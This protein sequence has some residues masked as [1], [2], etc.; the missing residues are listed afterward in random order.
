MKPKFWS[1]LAIMLMFAVV[2]YACAEGK[3]GPTYTVSSISGTVT[4]YGSAL[5]GVTITLSGASSATT[6]TDASGNYIFKGLA[7]G[8]YTVT[9]SMKGYI[10]NPVS[11]PVTIFGV[12]STGDNFAVQY[13]I[14]SGTVTGPSVSGILV[15]LSGVSSTTT[16]TTDASGKYTFKV[17]AN[18]TYT[19]TPSMTG[20]TFSP[21]NIAVTISGADS[22][23]DNFATQLGGAVQSNP[24]KLAM[25]VSTLA[26]LAGTDGSADGTGT[27]AL[28]HSPQGITSDGTNLYV[29][30]AGND[31]IRQI[32][33]STGAVTTL[34]GKAGS[35]GSADGTGT[36]ALF[37]SPQG[38]TSD[39]TNLYIAD[40]GNNTIR[41]ISKNKICYPG[42]S[43]SFCSYT[44]NTVTTLAGKA[45]S[46]GSADGTGTAA[47]FNSPQG[48]TTDG[49]N[50]YVADTGNDTIRQ[51]VI[52]TGAVTTLVGTAGTS[53]SID[54]TGT[55]A[56]FNS[57]QGI[58]MDVTNLYVADA[59]N[60]TIRQI[61]IA[62]GAVTTLAGT[63]GATGSADGTGTAARF[64]SPQGITMD[65]TDLY[66]A[67]TGNDTIR[68]IVIA[69]GAVTT[70]VGTAG[71]TGSTDGTG[72]AARFYYPEGMT[73][74]GTN[75]YVADTGNDTIRKIQ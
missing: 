43:A 22:T 69:T 19:V 75:L 52:S 66:V 48:I 38:I 30:D 54:G 29:A 12:T 51:I 7:N 17:L 2:L 13:Y 59:G 34:A 24:L 36:A 57:P 73:T 44:L 56:R 31:T 25:A 65:V 10:F 8:E 1:W 72:T 60:D 39:G 16:T 18:G 33:I 6:T 35:S 63:A 9:P 45:G 62:T 28:F 49:I 40:T 64:N 70:L 21:L 5:Q 50:L 53:G 37:H 20:Y 11:R 61:V 3:T 58:T 4:L 27:A 26:G 42:V 47:L 74:D 67:D 55:A 71:S 14:I 46:S 68:Q 41:K 15:T 32:V 23:E